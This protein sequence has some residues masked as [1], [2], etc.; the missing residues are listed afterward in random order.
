M[1]GG[2]GTAPFSYAINI[3]TKNLKRK[4]TS[5]VVLQPLLALASPTLLIKCIGDMGAATVADTATGI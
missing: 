2:G 4:T 3:T 5:D 1:Y